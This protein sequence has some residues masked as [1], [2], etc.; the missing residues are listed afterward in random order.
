MWGEWSH[1]DE[2]KRANPEPGEGERRKLVGVWDLFLECCDADDVINGE[3][4]RVHH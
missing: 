2:L 1:T 4:R 3:G